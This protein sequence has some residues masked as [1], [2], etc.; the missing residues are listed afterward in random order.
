MDQIDNQPTVPSPL[1][2]NASRAR[3]IIHVFYAICAMNV[4]SIISKSYQ[5]YVIDQ[6]QYGNMITDQQ[7]NAIDSIDRLIGI[8][9][10]CLYATSAILF[11]N[12]FRR[13]YGNLHR[14]EVPLRY[15]ETMAV[16]SFFIPIISLYRPYRIAKEILI[17]TRTKVSEFL[18]QLTSPIDITIIGVW[19]AF[20]LVKNTLGQIVTRT[21][22]ENATIER[23]VRYNWTYIASDI[24][25][26]AAA[27]VTILMILKISRD[28]AILFEHTSHHPHIS[29]PSSDEISHS[30]DIPPSSQP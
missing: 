9:Q 21:S 29:Q 25:D 17:E 19:W 10:I 8:V 27:V 2:D 20:Y 24:V 7:A 28:E 1:L 6:L 13:A 12:W 4:V 26:I 11:L 16:W 18:Q 5:L 15:S 22:L 30:I 23:L 14:L 3:I